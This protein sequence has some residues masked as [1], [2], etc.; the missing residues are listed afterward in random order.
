LGEKFISGN[1][2]RLVPQQEV[3][4]YFAL[5]YQTAIPAGEWRNNSPSGK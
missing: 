1:I 2:D 5:D 4:I 3:Y